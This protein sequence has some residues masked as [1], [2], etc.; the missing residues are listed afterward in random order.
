MMEADNHKILNSTQAF[1]HSYLLDFE[2]YD[3]RK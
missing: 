2:K 3:E 1:V